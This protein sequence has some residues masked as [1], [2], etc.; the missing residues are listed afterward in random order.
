MAP[1]EINVDNKK[2]TSK[3][4]DNTTTKV[5][6]PAD[7]IFKYTFHINKSNYNENN[8]LQLS[9]ISE[10]D[11]ILKTLNNLPN[12]LILE[13]KKSKISK[14]INNT[15]TKTYYKVFNKVTYKMMMYLVKIEESE[16]LTWEIYANKNKNVFTNSIISMYKIKYPSV[17]IV[18][19]IYP[20]IEDIIEPNDILFDQFA[21]NL[22]LFNKTKDILDAYDIYVMYDLN[23]EML[24]SIIEIDDIL[25][26]PYISADCIFIPTDTRSYTKNIN[27]EQKTKIYL[28]QTDIFDYSGSILLASVCNYS[29]APIIS[30]KTMNQRTGKVNEIKF[31]IFGKN[32]KLSEYSN[33]LKSEIIN[34]GI[35]KII[36]KLV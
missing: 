10:N 32:I 30:S 8:L 16:D 3:I 28:D 6:K 15:I 13:I 7:I 11:I 18:K 27:D 36:G 20:S 1:N 24:G 9:A 31:I 35:Y 5:N 4:I 26:K 21:N 22:K 34:N 25:F 29:E 33:T 19:S 14:D 17:D 23:K 12:I 2:F